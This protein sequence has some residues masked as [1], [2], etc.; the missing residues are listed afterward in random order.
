MSQDYIFLLF[1]GLPCFSVTVDAPPPF[2]KTL[3]W[4]FTVMAT[5]QGQC[6]HGGP[7]YDTIDIT[8]STKS[9]ERN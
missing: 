7:V 3:L 8:L 4:M 6:I 1:I 5:S 9:A 2:S